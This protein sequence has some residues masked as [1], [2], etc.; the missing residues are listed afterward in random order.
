MTTKQTQRLAW[1]QDFLEKRQPGYRTDPAGLN[2]EDAR[3]G[4]MANIPFRLVPSYDELFRGWFTRWF[5]AATQNKSSGKME[6]PGGAMGTTIVAQLAL[7][8]DELR[9]L[10]IGKLVD[11]RADIVSVRKN[12]VNPWFAH[13][14]PT[15]TEADIDRFME[16]CL[17][18]AGF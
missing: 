14:Q 5:R 1:L 7:P 13:N 2:K 6:Y 12:T 17:S 15:A 16:D 4:A 8:L 3:S 18:V 9:D 11:A 10:A